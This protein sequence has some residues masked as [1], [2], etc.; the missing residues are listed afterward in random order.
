MQLAKLVFVA[1]CIFSANTNPDMLLEMALTPASLYIK[2]M[3]FFI[4]FKNAAGA[5]EP[6]PHF[7]YDLVIVFRKP[8]SKAEYR[9]KHANVKV[10]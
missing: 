1:M 5:Q 7:R 8:T 3:P 2:R 4:E 9:Q 10:L 6:I